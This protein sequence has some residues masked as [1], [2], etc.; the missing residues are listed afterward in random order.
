L[1]TARIQQETTSASPGSG[2]LLPHD[3]FPPQSTSPTSYSGVRLPTGTGALCAVV[4]E[5]QPLADARTA[6]P[7]V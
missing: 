6:I 2:E 3:I 4:S 7:G 5:L 1:L